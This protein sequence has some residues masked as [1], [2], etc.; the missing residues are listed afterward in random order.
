MKGWALDIAN[1]LPGET[2]ANCEEIQKGAGADR[3][4]SADR[5]QESQ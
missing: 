4:V 1:F 3:T 2:G 5:D